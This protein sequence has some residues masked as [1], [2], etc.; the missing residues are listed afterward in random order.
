MARI[1]AGECI[2][3]V[4]LIFFHVLEPEQFGLSYGVKTIFEWACDEQCGMESNETLGCK[5][6][7]LLENLSTSFFTQIVQ[8]HKLMI[9]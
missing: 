6:R 7:F 3:C 9:V 2:L 1:S 5:L 4:G 8:N